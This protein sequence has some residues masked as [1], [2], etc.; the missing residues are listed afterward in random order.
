MDLTKKGIGAKAAAVLVAANHAD[1]FP[2]AKTVERAFR[3]MMLGFDKLFLD[4]LGSNPAKRSDASS[5]YDQH[6]DELPSLE[7]FC[8]VFAGWLDKYHSTPKHG[9]KANGSFA[10]RWAIR[11]PRSA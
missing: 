11:M 3:D 9:K 1:E 8:K 2:R 10:L 7:A 4:Y 6:P 5:Y